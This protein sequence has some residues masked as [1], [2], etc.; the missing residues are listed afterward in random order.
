MNDKPATSDIRGQFVMAETAAAAVL[1]VIGLVL[2]LAVTGPVADLAGSV[3]VLFAVIAL[4]HAIA[5]ALGF[6]APGPPG[7]HQPR[8]RSRRSRR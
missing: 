5:V 8:E 4:G 7:E 1:G 2:I 3:L 6:A